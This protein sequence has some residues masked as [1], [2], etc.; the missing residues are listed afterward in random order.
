MTKRPT[1]TL[2]PLPRW[3]SLLRTRGRAGDP[4]ADLHNTL[5]VLRNEPGF[6]VSFAFDEMQQVTIVRAK[7]PLCAGADAGDDFPRWATDEDVSRLQEWLQMVMPK[8]S[9]ENVFNALEEFAREN[10]VHPLRLWLRTREIGVRQP[11]LE[12]WLSYALGVP[13]DAYH[14]EVG[15]RFAIAMVARVFDP[16]CQADYM[17][18]LE[19]PQGEEKSK[20]CRA[21]A[22]DQYFS[23]HIPSLTGDHVRFSMHLR[24]KWLIEISELAAF[25]K[26]ADVESL[27]ALITRRVEI[28]TPKYGRKERHEPRQCVFIGTTNTDDWNRDETGGRRFWPVK[29]AHVDLEWLAEYRDQ[30]FAEAVAAYEAGE[31][32]WPD[33]NFER[34]IIAPQQDK[35]LFHDAWEET[36]AQD[37]DWRATISIADAA[38]VIGI[39]RERLDML[40]Q[41][42]LGAILR[43]LKWTKALDGK[44]RAIWRKPE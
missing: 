16:G 30:L 8:L 41:K 11:V 29:V 18:V 12:N 44:G 31:P 4:I 22:S 1:P 10:P 35:R 15:R 2:V 13:N 38:Q 24:G 3:R 40:A 32:H 36:L 7:P 33:R 19:G 28:Y 42:R 27:K 14:R 37:L 43:K 26:V 23:D 5:I 17:I 6:A 39:P 34:R 9:R 21:L 25:N 20:F